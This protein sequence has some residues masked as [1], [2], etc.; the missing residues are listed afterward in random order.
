MISCAYSMKDIDSGEF[1]F[2]FGVTS[3]GQMYSV[4]FPSSQHT[5]DT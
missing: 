3:Y 1:S 5:E 4:A 2:I